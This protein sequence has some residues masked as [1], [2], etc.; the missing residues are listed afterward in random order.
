[1]KNKTHK[2]IFISHYTSVRLLLRSLSYLGLETVIR[3]SDQRVRGHNRSRQRHNHQRQPVWFHLV[4]QRHSIAKKVGCFR[5]NLFVCL[6]VLYVCLFVNTIAS[7]WVNTGWW[8]L[9]VGALYKNLGWVRIWGHSPCRDMQPPE[10]CGVLWLAT[11]D[12]KRKQSH[13]GRRNITCALRN[14]AQA[15]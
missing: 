2:F 7:E 11:H 6:W 9:G 5:R 1:M 8:N 14:S 13:A 15:V 12:A 3:F 10:N 4:T